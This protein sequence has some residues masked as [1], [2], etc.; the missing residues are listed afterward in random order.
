MGAKE[1]PV[2]AITHH[3]MTLSFL[4]ERWRAPSSLAAVTTAAWAATI[5]MFAATAYADA[6]QRGADASFLNVLLAYAIGLGPWIILAPT[7][8]FISRRR[9]FSDTSLLRRAVQA[10]SLSSCSTR[11]LSMRH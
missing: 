5:L 10:S 9:L 7:V 8:I 2:S 3:V 1:E 11:C 6:T 4:P